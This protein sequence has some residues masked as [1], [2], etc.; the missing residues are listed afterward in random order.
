MESF[1]RELCDAMRSAG[2][3]AAALAARTGLTEGA[4]SYL[5]S[6]RREPS[7]R[8]MRALS[9]ALPQLAARFDVGR[10]TMDSIESAIADIK[11]GKIV[12]YRSGKK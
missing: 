1:A 8:S 2:L 6:G 9:A 12:E 4:I 11:A 10:R 7:F 3:S 5:R